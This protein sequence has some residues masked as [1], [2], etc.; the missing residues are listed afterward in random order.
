MSLKT[1]KALV[2]WLLRERATEADEGPEVNSLTPFSRWK[3]SSKKEKKKK[4]K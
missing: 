1:T 3:S 2:R 4:G